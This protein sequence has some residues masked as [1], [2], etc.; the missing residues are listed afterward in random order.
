ML[1]TITAVSLPK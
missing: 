1:T